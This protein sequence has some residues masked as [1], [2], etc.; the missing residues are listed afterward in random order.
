M[1][2][3]FRYHPWIEE[4]K[5][6]IVKLQFLSIHGRRCSDAGGLRSLCAAVERR[7]SSLCS[8]M[9]CGW[10][11]LMDDCRT[12][13]F[14]R[15]VS[16]GPLVS[17]PAPLAQACQSPVVFFLHSIDNHTRGLVDTVFVLWC[18]DDLRP[19]RR[20]FGLPW[21][22]LG[23]LPSQISALLLEEWSLYAF[24]RSAVRRDLTHI[25][26][27]WGFGPLVVCFASLR[28]NCQVSEDH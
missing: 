4:K 28:G 21:T 10:L 12:D 24:V 16:T 18:V 26:P 5:C 7:I 27:D 3:L 14:R 1:L 22:R 13:V 6:G 2:P 8:Q 17:A 11:L 23:L 15:Q 25:L 20:H 19:C 9:Q